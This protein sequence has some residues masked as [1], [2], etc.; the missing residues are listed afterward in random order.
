MKRILT[1]SALAILLVVGCTA[2]AAAP[3]RVVSLKPSITDTVY[4]LGLGEKLVGITKYCDVPK[5]RRRPEVAADYTR[6]YMER[7]VA[8]RPDV[9][10]GSEENSSRR[11]IE[12]LRRAGLRVELYP[13]GTIEEMLSSIEAIARDLGAPESGRRLGAKVR[14][15]L[16]R[17]KLQSAKARPRRTVVV[18]GLRPM[19]IAG[20]GTYMDEAMLYVGLANAAAD[21]GVR[22]P[23]IGL[24]RLIGLNPEV[25][26][27]LS[28]D[29][30]KGERP[31]D[32]V[33]SIDAVRDG[34]IIS[35]EPAS[36]R[37]GPGLPAALDKLAR[38]IH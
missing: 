33:D 24:E 15:E 23:K 18:W 11:S 12:A 1:I 4:A 9:V 35:M 7:I 30:G 13:F 5:G 10:M 17:L 8:L 22:Y 26:V 36:F 28:M 20:S 21:V 29:A 3:K 34:R 37:A 16:E 32:G 2:H 14:G 19:I 6:P 31:W 38:A 25:I 27:D